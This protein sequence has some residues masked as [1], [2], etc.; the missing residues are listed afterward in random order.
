MPV[1]DKT[2]KCG[3]TN[4]IDN[5]ETGGRYLANNVIRFGC[6]TM[7]E[8]YYYGSLQFILLLLEDEL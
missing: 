1:D 8:P 7:P 3:N 6:G 2:S 5:F 4:D